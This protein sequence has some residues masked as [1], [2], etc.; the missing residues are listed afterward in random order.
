MTLRTISLRPNPKPAKRR[1]QGKKKKKRARRRERREKRAEFMVQGFR[2]CDPLYLHPGGKFKAAM[3]GAMH[4]K[5]LRQADAAM[6]SYSDNA[7]TQRLYFIQT[8][9]A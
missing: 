5:T 3:K 1:R 7:R 2:L 8:V 4:F 6:R 9:P